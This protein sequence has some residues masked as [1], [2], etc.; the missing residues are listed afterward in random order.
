MYSIL[1]A[2]MP[3]ADQFMKAGQPFILE[4]NFESSE[5]GN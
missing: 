4:N 5:H 2:G 1:V 3:A